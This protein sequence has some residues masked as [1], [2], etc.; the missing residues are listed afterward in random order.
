MNLKPILVAALVLGAAAC[1]STSGTGGSTSSP[2]NTGG[3][4]G[5]G[6]T[7]STSSASSGGGSSSSGG[8]GGATTGSGGGGGG[9]ASVS[10]GS[11]S[12]G[13][14]GPCEL[15][16]NTMNFT[17]IQ[18]PGTPTPTCGDVQPIT[19]DGKV[20]TENGLIYVDTC[21]PNAGCAAKEIRISVAGLLFTPDD[22]Q[23][24]P[25]GTFVHVVW[26]S[27]YPAPSSGACGR[28]LLV[29]NLPTW[30]GVANPIASH[31]SLWLF[32]T[33][34][35]A[36]SQVGAADDRTALEAD[37]VERCTSQ[38]LEPVVAYDLKLKATDANV[39]VTAMNGH[40]ASLSIPSGA[41]KGEYAMINDQVGVA[42]NASL[43]RS[44]YV[45]RLAP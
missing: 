16:G 3:A 13:S 4:G 24:I 20:R 23:S 43:M 15:H 25:N 8:S 40:R 19:F 2:S 28:A 44:Y 14:G 30:Q 38:D 7:S 37:E 27:L 17:V 32:A 9:G 26:S 6:S 34:G 31:K 42:G 33:L 41:Q 39:S 22:A 36:L 18:L 5:A 45:F 21:G 29:R 11:S 10:V 12:S 35:P 1:G